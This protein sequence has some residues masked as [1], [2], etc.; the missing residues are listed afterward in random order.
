MTR[1]RMQSA[2]FTDGS[3][4]PLLSL[5]PVP[6]PEPQASTR[7]VIS[8]DQIML[9]EP[10]CRTCMDLG[11]LRV[12]KRVRFCWCQAGQEMHRRKSG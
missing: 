2:L 11:E 5:M 8:P 3:D 12:G 10:T 9:L 4:L 1:G 7:T 6:V